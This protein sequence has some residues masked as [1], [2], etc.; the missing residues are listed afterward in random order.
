M[1]GVVPAKGSNLNLPRGR[2]A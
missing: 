2:G 1:I